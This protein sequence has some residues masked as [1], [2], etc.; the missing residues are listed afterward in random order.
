[1]AKTF[2]WHDYETWGTSARFTQSVQFA[3]VRT[4]LDFNQIGEP[5]VIYNRPFPDLLPD[6]MAVMVT[7]ITPQIAEEK[8]V[9]EPE[10]VAAIHKELSQP[11]TIGVGY[12]SLRFDDEFTRF[13]LYR[14]FYD[15]YRREW[16]NGNSTW[17]VIDLVRATRALRPDGIEWPTDTDGK[18]TNT[19]EAIT[20]A[21]GIAHEDAHDALSDVRATIEIA[22]LIKSKQPQLFEF[23]LRLRDKREAQSQL[24]EAH[25]DKQPLVHVSGKFPNEF[26]NTSI[27]AVLGQDARIKTKYLA[28]DL[29]F[30]P[31]QFFEMDVEQLKE[32]IFTSREELDGKDRLPLKQ[33]A[34]NKSPF[35]APLKV[36]DDSAQKRMQLSAEQAKKHQDLLLSRSDFL[37]KLQKIFTLDDREPHPDVDTQLYDG[38]FGDDDRQLLQRLRSTPPQEWGVVTSSDKRIAKLANRYRARHY[39]DTLGEDEQAQWEKHRAER[40][41]APYEETFMTF[42]EYARQLQRLTQE[43]ADDKH[44]TFV[45]GELQLYGQSIYPIEE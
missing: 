10:F 18:A 6:P 41:L 17:D 4:D 21:N 27:V 5:L 23:A 30:D 25:R 42:D 2:Y 9:P 13:A 31:K 38:F 37:E 20:A 43:Y 11:G 44:K 26:C 24:D 16:D 8:G 7:G 19:L 33:I 29:R 36:L 34:T 35:I 15:P 22:R 3:G 12:N 39:P 28:Y 14:N 45:L 1:M 32:R 40:L